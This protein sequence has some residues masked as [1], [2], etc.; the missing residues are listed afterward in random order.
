[1]Q[2]IQL[3]TWNAKLYSPLEYP[4]VPLQVGQDV[5]CQFGRGKIIELRTTNTPT[6]SCVEPDQ[7]DPQP[8]SE[9][10]ASTTTTMV[11]VQLSSWRLAHRSRVLLYLQPLSITAVV[12]SKQPYEMNVYEKVEYAQHIKDTLANPLFQQQ[13]YAAAWQAYLQAVH[14]VKYVQH[15]A[16]SNNYVRA[17]LIV[18]MITCCNNAALCAMHLATTA[19][20]PTN[21]SAMTA[22]TK[23]NNNNHHNNNNNSHKYWEQV[24][25]LANQALALLDALYLKRGLRI[26]T[27]LTTKPT[28]TKPI[29]TTSTSTTTTTFYT[30]AKLFGEWRVKSLVLMA[31]ALLYD[32]L[33]Y[34]AAMVLLKRAHEILVDYSTPTNHEYDVALLPSLQRQDKEVRRLVMLVK[35]K[36]REAKAKE[37]NV[38]KAMFASTS[39]TTTTTTTTTSHHHN[40]ASNKNTVSPKKDLND[41][42]NGNDMA[43]EKKDSANSSP[44]VRNVKTAGK[45]AATFEKKVSFAPDV[46]GSSTPSPNNTNNATTRGVD[47][48]QQEPDERDSGDDEEEAEEDSF[49][50]QHQE[51][52]I[53]TGAVAFIGLVAMRILFSRRA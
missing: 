4:S 34:D 49:L 23:T 25:S 7:Q 8:S 35:E 20:A 48:N 5:L 2:E 42:R 43:E 50:T 39:T 40:D 28:S 6:K 30:D 9:Q 15:D 10:V 19:D 1:M 52:L 22:T 13:Q 53:L 38:A 27:L 26:H 47:M 3:T 12:R 36:K 46:K 24:Y 18:L 37:R 33:E 32:Q 44:S 17:D 51:A 45:A 31:K 16:Q 29:S 14:V 21:S 11:V 41:T